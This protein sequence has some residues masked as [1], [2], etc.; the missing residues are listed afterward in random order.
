M[1][2]LK[3]FSFAPIREVV[4]VIT[5]VSAMGWLLFFTAF[6]FIRFAMRVQ[7][8]MIEK[9]QDAAYLKA[10]EEADRLDYAQYTERMAREKAR[11]EA[12][13]AVKRAE[14]AKHMKTLN[15]KVVPTTITQLRAARNTAMLDNHP[16]V[17]GEHFQATEI[18]DA[19]TKLLK[20]LGLDPN[21]A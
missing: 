15:L 12:A 14:M 9:A 20:R 10:H 16:D 3:L 21:A 13:V 8:K 6:H 5:E 1:K 2:T 17:G 11:Y 7:I 18:N 19:Y 4:V